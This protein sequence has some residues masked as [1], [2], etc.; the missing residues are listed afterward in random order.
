[1][2]RPLKDAKLLR[3]ALLF[4]LGPGEGNTGMAGTDARALKRAVDRNIP[5]ID[6]PA[7]IMK[8]GGLDSLLRA[9]RRADGEDDEVGDE[10]EPGEEADEKVWLRFQTSPEG[11]AE[12]LSGPNEGKWALLKPKPARTGAPKSLVLDRLE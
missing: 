10:E 9:A 8:S 6:L 4:T 3:D 11:A 1:M 5:A 12:L 7:Y 2:Q